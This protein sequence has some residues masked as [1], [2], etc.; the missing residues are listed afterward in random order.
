MIARAIAAFTLGVI[1]L[2]MA[3]SARRDGNM[4]SFYARIICSQIWLVGA[5]VLSEMVQ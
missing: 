5:F 1:W 3:D 4:P 2:V